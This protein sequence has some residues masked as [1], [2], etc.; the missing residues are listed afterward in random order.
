MGF[1]F[2]LSILKLTLDVNIP[3]SIHMGI[4]Q[5]GP[6]FWISKHTYYKVMMIEIMVEMM[7]TMM[8]ALMVIIKM[9]I[10]IIAMMMMT[11]TM[12]W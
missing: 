10:L 11:V 4:F 8:V 6:K 2:C 12:T 3:F 9:V 1:W 7:I 5:N